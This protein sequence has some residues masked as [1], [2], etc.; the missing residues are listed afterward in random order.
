SRLADVR[1]HTDWRHHMAH[2]DPDRPRCT[3]LFV[4]D[5]N[6]L[7]DSVEDAGRRELLRA[8][9]GLGV[10]CE[11]VCRLTLPAEQPD[12]GPGLAEHGWEAEAASDP[13]A[14]PQVH[15]HGVLV[16]LVP[17]PATGAQAPS[18]APAA[19]LGVVESAL[20]RQSPD[21]VLVRSGP[22]LAD[23]L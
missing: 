8:L 7:E 14:P 4:T 20:Q 22:C 3:A 23:V 21:V 12:P 18:E 5:A 6:F 15:A 13:G 2:P 9:L 16:T 17:G 11:V 19:L 10:S 1:P